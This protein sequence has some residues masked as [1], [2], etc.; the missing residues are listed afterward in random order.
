MNS[1]QIKVTGQVQGVGFRPF[2]YRQ[3]QQFKLCGR[4][5]NCSGEVVILVQGSNQQIKLF[6]Q[7]I[8]VEHP[9]LA[10]PVIA[11]ANWIDSQ[12]VTDFVIEKST[13]SEHTERHIPPDYFTCNDCL[14]EMS[15]PDERRFRYPFTNCTQCGPRYTIIR[16]LPYDRPNTSMNKFPLCHACHHEYTNTLDRRFHAQPLACSECGPELS[17]FLSEKNA[18]DEVDITSGNEACLAAAV[19]ALRQGKIL[20]VRGVGGYHLICDATNE[21]TVQNLRKRKHRPDKPLAVMFSAAADNK[22]E[23]LKNYCS[24][25][26]TESSTL[27]SPQRPIVLLSAIKNTLAPSINPGL[28]Q[29]GAMLAYSP[30]HYLLLQDF[31]LPVVATSGNLS[32]EPVLTDNTQA[33]ARLSNIADIFLQHNRPILRPADD[34]VMRIIQNKRRLFRIGRGIAPLEISLPYALKHVILAVGGQMKNTIAL[35]WGIGEKSRVVISPHIGELDSQRSI[36]VFTQVIDDLCHLYRLK[37]QQIICDKHPD[38]Y[39]SRYAKQYAK[40][41]NIPVTHV[42]HHHAHA[43]IVSGEFDTLN[44]G[45]K[46]PW[47][48]FSWDG[49]G[50]GEDQTIWGGEGF[51]GQSGHWQRVCSIKP[52]YLQGGDKAAKQPWR[53]ACALLWEQNKWSNEVH[54]AQNTPDSLAYQAWEKRINTHQC[55]SVGRLFDAASALLGLGDYSSFEGQGP[56]LLEA[57]LDEIFDKNTGHSYPSLPLYEQKTD[58]KHIIITADWSELLVMLMDNKQSIRTRSLC[59]HKRIAETL[60]KQAQKIQAIKGDIRIGLSGGVFQN[61]YLTEYLFMRLQEEHFEVFLPEKI[62]Y[63][64]AGLSF[65]QIIE[66]IRK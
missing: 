12:T 47:L 27:I 9:P 28:K 35:A 25:D 66:T 16:D 2:I 48:I 20:A 29:I 52:F 57:L 7:S 17:L 46:K 3:A 64:D 5:K 33:A 55:S 54:P 30:L 65:G 58:N 44:K 61:K 22:L 6:Q 63:N 19:T 50:L 18:D 40:K 14:D 53:S 39:S 31:G 56:M 21:Q 37:P 4:V 13:V 23:Q 62:P 51:Y 26:E 36:E 32:G 10:M 42:Q 8:L 24:P 60:I 49:T 43:G 59:F 41:H 34:S 11:S 15:N 1:L 38:Y 45:N